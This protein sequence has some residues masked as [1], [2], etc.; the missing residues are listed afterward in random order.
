M[1]HLD[2]A[3][4]SNS[5]IVTLQEKT[6]NSNPTYRLEL[7]NF[8][9]NETFYWTGLKSVANERKDIIT[10]TFSNEFIARIPSPGQYKY[11]FLEYLGLTAT[12]ISYSIVETGMAKIIDSSTQ[13]SYVYIQ[14][15]ETDDD[16]LTL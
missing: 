9:T 7:F 15:T 3:T 1:I 5:F 11:T 13:S 10:L 12:G 4:A 6:I 16:Y 8:Y 2:I 14:P